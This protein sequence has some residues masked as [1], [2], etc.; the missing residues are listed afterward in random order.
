[1]S[2]SQVQIVNMACAKLGDFYISSMSEGTKQAT[3]AGIFWENARDTLL[4]SYPWNFAIERA[5]L[6]LLAGTPT[7]QYTYKY[8]LP[9]NCLR[10]L[11]MSASGDFDSSQTTEYRIEGRTLVTNETKAYIKYIK[12]VTDTSNFP[13][14]FSKLLAC[15]LSLLLAEP[16]AAA[17]SSTKQLIMADREL[18]LS[19]ASRN[20]FNEGYN[21]PVGWYQM[22]Y[23]RDN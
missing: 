4:E 8:Q 23:V 19:E 1:M 7:W 16:L 9:N 6:A 21:Q 13:P 22:T 14:S 5:S 20:D 15:E 12:Q 11:D 18:A 2:L 3:Y 10:V 17:D